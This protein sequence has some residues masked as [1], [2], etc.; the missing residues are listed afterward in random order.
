MQNGQYSECFAVN[1]DKTVTNVVK[2]LEQRGL[3]ISTAESCTGGLLS[4]L[5][6]SVSG[7]SAVF[8]LGLCTYSEKMKMK[9]LGVSEAVLSQ[10]GV[11]SYETA[12]AM[13]QGLKK[14]SSADVCV[15]VTGIAGPG[16]G[17]EETPVGTIYV[18]FDICGKQFVRL[19]DLRNLHDKSRDN[20]RRT[21]AGYAFGIIEEI[22]MKAVQTN[23]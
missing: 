23:E 17:T 16:G 9:Y 5:I 2:L 13:V 14:C 7:A 8:E 22:L 1:L 18:G 6:T 15:S 10:Y 3:T 4:E 11:V 21:V 12:L 20:L 19:P